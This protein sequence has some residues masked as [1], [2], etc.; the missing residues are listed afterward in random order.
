MRRL[1]KLCAIFGA[2]VSVLAV[3]LYGTLRGGWLDALLA[4]IAIG[5][6][7]LPEELPVVLAVAKGSLINKAILVPL[8]LGWLHGDLWGVFLLAGTSGVG[9]TE[10]ALALRP[11]AV[12]LDADGADGMFRHYKSGVFDDTNCGTNLD[13]APLVVGYTADYWILKNSWGKNWGEDGYLRIPRNKNN[14]CGVASFAS[15]PL[16]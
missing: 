15:Y 9:K 5:M 12:S 11:V 1:V 2:V 6:S 7:M 13:H 10:T 4:G 16:V 8:A 14:Y 3:V